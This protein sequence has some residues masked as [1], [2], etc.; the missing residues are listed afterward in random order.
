MSTHRESVQPYSARHDAT[1]RHHCT[2]QV[3]SVRPGVIG[4]CTG[5]LRHHDRA[6]VMQ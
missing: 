6:G 5:H 1:V 2:I 3:L 4:G